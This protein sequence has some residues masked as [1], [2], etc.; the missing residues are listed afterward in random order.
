M[1]T[2]HFRSVCVHYVAVRVFFFFLSLFVKSC[3]YFYIKFVQKIQ[4]SLV[5]SAYPTVAL[6]N[7]KAVL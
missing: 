3:R 2:V 4:W 6:A 7:L 5:L 1:F